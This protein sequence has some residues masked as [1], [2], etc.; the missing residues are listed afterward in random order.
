MTLDDTE[1]SA[2]V[3]TIKA[4]LRLFGPSLDPDVVHEADPEL[5]RV[6]AAALR[7]LRRYFRGEVLGLD[8]IP[9]GPA[10]LVGNHNAGIT[11][12]EPFLLGLA[13]YERTGE[14][15]TSLG[16]DA[17]VALPVV[18]NLL[19]KLGTIRADHE[20]AT[21]ALASGRKVLVMPGG[22]Y[23]SFRPYWRRHRID[24]GHHAGY[25]KLALGA[26]VPIVPVLCLGGH[27][28]F[29]VLS[30]GHSLARITGVK[31]YLRSDSFPIFLGLPWGLGVGPIFHLPLPARL[32]VEVGEPID[33]SA[34]QPADAANLEVVRE[35]SARVQSRLQQLMD[36]RA[37]ERRWPVLG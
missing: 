21:R 9:A 27:E 34:Y 4:L 13:W 15:L 10:L 14:L 7:L 1:N 31:K 26:Q 22:N 11:A 12:M 32:L 35:I 29:F 8:R 5:N 23:E 20:V 25:V 18:G 3:A 37:A 24:F 28:T 30:S 16:H 33:L 17:M 6:V 19:V 36:R 2:V